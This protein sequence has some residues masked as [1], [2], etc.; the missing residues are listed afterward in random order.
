MLCLGPHWGSWTWCSGPLFC[1]GPLSGSC[2]PLPP[3]A[4]LCHPC[5]RLPFNICFHTSRH[6][7]SL[8]FPCSLS[9]CFS[10]VGRG[11]RKDQTLLSA[12]RM[13]SGCIDGLWVVDVQVLAQPS[14]GWPY[15]PCGVERAV[16]VVL[17]EMEAP[18]GREQTLVVTTSPLVNRGRSSAPER[19]VL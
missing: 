2:F 16:S 19:S 6:L 5:T 15:A 11:S 17:P 3:P 10:R 1:W 7:S 13:D 12:P 4:A 8:S 9:L 14:Q 18:P